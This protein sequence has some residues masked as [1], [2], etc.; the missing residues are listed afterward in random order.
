MHGVADVHLVCRIQAVF[1]AHKAR[2]K[3]HTEACKVMNSTGELMP[4]P[5]TVRGESG[6]YQMTR[7]RV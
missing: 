4:M 5:G 7:T 6:W 2:L 3:L 1:R